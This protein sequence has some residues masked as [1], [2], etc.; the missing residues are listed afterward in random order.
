MLDGSPQNLTTLQY[1]D[2]LTSNVQD[3]IKILGND[4]FF[5]NVPLPINFSMS[6]TRLI[7]NQMINHLLYWHQ[8]VLSFFNQFIVLE[9]AIFIIIVL[10]QAGFLA[11]ISVKIYRMF[12][13]KVDVLKLFLEI[14][15]QN[16]RIMSIKT[17]Q[18]LNTLYNNETDIDD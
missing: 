7:Y 3:I 5:T 6:N 12:N 8:T 1:I 11:L 15:E 4:Y 14:S 17:E 13:E 2:A 10:F 9:S 16:V 18:F